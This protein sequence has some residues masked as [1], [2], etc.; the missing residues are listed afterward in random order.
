M[1][2]V[3]MGEGQ[4]N[5]VCKLWKLLRIHARIDHKFVTLLFNYEAGVLVLCDPHGKPPAI[6]LCLS[7]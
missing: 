5:D 1:V 3:D 4:R 2:I 6:S 7:H